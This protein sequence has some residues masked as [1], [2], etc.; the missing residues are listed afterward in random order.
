MAETQGN[1]KQKRGEKAEKAIQKAL[2]NEPFPGVQDS[3]RPSR[4][5]QVPPD[6][7][8]MKSGHS[9]G[10]RNPYGKEDIPDD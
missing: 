2:E 5:G 4:M 7:E 1:S 8:K 10:H 6:R 3:G 9:G